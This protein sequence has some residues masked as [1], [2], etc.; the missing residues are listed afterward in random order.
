MTTTL[1]TFKGWTI[2][3]RLKQ[4]RKI[5]RKSR[6]FAAMEYLDFKS[7]QGDRILTKYIKTLAPNS[8]EL[9]EIARAIL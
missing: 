3:A 1:P 5:V 6:H 2:D 9:N 7:E 8:E 4:L